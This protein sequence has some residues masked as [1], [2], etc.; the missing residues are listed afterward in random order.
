MNQKF[1]VIT[2]VRRWHFK[3]PRWRKKIIL[4]TNKSN[5]DFQL[6]TGKPREPHSLRH[7][8]MNIPSVSRV[9]N[10]G[11]SCGR[12]L[13]SI[14]IKVFF[15]LKIPD[16]FHTPTAAPVAAKNAARWRYRLPI[17]NLTVYYNSQF[18]ISFHFSFGQE[19]QQC[20]KICL[21]WVLT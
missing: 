18:C 3:S 8:I 1:S 20:L 6:C 12:G 15:S 9:R 4:K 19:A 14:S 10:S 21:N 17:K 5:S 2:E 13:R 11:R 7:Q 16:L